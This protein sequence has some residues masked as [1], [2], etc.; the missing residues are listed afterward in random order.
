MKQVSFSLVEFAQPSPKTG[1]IDS[2]TGFSEAAK[3]GLEIHKRLQDEKAETHPHYQAEV[4]IAHTFHYKKI[5]VT[6]SGRMDGIYV[7]EKVIIEEIKTAFDAKRLASSLEETYFTHPYWLQL[8]TYG[9][10]YWL[11]NKTLP[12]LKLLIV[13]LRN[14]KSFELK[15]NLDISMYEEWLMVR[16]SEINE[17][18]NLAHKRILRRKKVAKA[19]SFPFEK[20]RLQQQALIDSINETMKIKAPLLIQA[21]TGLGKTMGVLFPVLQES[22]QRG[23]KTFYLTPKNSQHR[24]VIEASKLLQNKNTAIKILSLSAKK[25]LCMKE[26]PICHSSYCEF[27]KSHFTK[28]TEHQLLK[29]SKRL[30]HLDKTY[31]K[32]I[33]NRYEI[34]PYEL[35]M[36]SI[37]NADLIIGDYNYVFSPQAPNAYIKELPLGE[38][39]KCNLI[40]DEAHNLPARSLDYYSPTLET[41]FLEN[42][43]EKLLQLPASITKKALLC[44]QESIN[45]IKNYGDN[46][47]PVFVTPSLKA[48]QHQLEKINTLLSE[49]FE[50]DLNITRGDPILSLYQYWLNFTKALEIIQEPEVKEAFFV[51]ADGHQQGLKITCCEASFFLKDIY[52][53][54]K[55][56]VAFSATLKPFAYYSQMLGL[57]NP[58]TR[59]FLSPFS[60]ANRKL[61]FIPQLS[62]KYTVRKNQESKLITAINKI[63]QVKPGNYLLFFPSFEYLNQIFQSFPINSNLTLLRQ[64][65]GMKESETNELLQQLKDSKEPHLIF[66]VQGGVLAEGINYLGSMAIGAFIIGPSLSSFSWEKEQ[67]KNYYQQH[68][69]QGQAY[70]YIYPAMARAVQAAGRVIRSEHDKGLLVF[71][72]ERFLNKNYFKCMPEDWFNEHPREHLSYSI[73]KDLDHFWQ[74]SEEENKIQSLLTL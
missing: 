30:K 52:K 34:C 33:A 41:I 56:V 2:Y 43:R 67:I 45:L 35:Q 17:S 74:G 23:Q 19:L 24:E 10:L 48:F 39:Q 32:K 69:E 61:L 29:K 63:I 54:F 3:R 20:P 21:P 44:L 28:V 38:S 7:G 1:S 13:S 18:L 53:Q 70:T 25:K 9:Y 14:K 49:Y 60:A 50:L 8:Q 68:Y 40:I 36:Q 55:Q 46:L 15:L 42:L 12:D 6:I 22:L 5:K 58:E 64:I 66:A 16:L 57:A 4:P 72:D 37:A 71:M 31:F 73:L 11:K 26:E 59:E 65:Q 62:T 51:W 27:A 47:S